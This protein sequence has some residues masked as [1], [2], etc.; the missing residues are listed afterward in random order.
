MVLNF[1]DI[2]A[3]A[4]R[5]EQHA[6]FVTF[7]CNTLGLFEGA[8]AS[9]EGPVTALIMERAQREQRVNPGL[10]D[11]LIGAFSGDTAKGMQTAHNRQHVKL[12]VRNT[13]VL[14]LEGQFRRAL[15]D[16]SERE[17]TV[18]RASCGHALA[19]RGNTDLREEML[20]FIFQLNAK[21]AWGGGRGQFVAS[22]QAARFASEAQTAAD[23]AREMMRRHINDDAASYEQ[24][25]GDMLSQF[26]QAAGHAEFHAR[27]PGSA[28]AV[29]GVIEPE[30]TLWA[31]PDHIEAGQTPFKR[32]QPG[33]DLLLG[34]LPLGAGWYPVGFAGHESLVTVAQPG[35]G[36]TQCHVLP[37]LLSYDGAM[38]VLDPKLELLELTAGHRQS[39]GKRILVLNLADDDQPSHKFNVL[40]FIDTRPEFLW[41]AV[42]E[43]AEFLIP[44]VPGDHSPIF[45]AKA[46]ELLATCLG[47]VVLAAQTAGETPTLTKA[48]AHIFSAPLSLQGFLLDTQDLAEELGCTPLAQSAAALAS[49][50]ANENTLEDFQRYQTNATSALMKYRGGLVDR[51][52]DGP[53]EWRPE[54]LR[55]P[56]TTLYIRIPYEEMSVYGG[57]VRLVLYT[58]I[59]RLRKTP[60]DQGGLPITFLLDEIAQLGNLDA[61]AN[62]I[63][64]GRGFGLRVWLILQDYDQARAASSKPNLI[65]KTPKVRLFM[66]PSLETAQ[67]MSAQLGSINEILTGKDKPIAQ[68]AELMGEAFNDEVV[69]LSSGCRPLCLK[70]Y[71]AYRE[72]GYT[73]MTSRPERFIR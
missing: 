8:E 24:E 51:V 14:L 1:D 36:K 70:K 66:N 68:P 26:V 57:F 23:M 44:E 42:I 3:L 34:C 5:A 67:E 11:Q 10:M 30:R 40:D 13:R 39:E 50:A 19:Q 63:E 15:A 27:Y 73:A 56:G 45:R 49:L 59:K 37:N 43:V 54:D 48:I 64:T 53:S 7:D 47:G 58:L 12:Y 41:G 61:I 6:G 65:L 38:V 71:F 72:E 17:L 4:Q 33:Q 25:I 31:K 18:L 46:A 21:L 62:V 32:F 29:A 22:A 16:L 52:A 28:Q 20:R 55:T 35:A 2:A 69:V 60:T 9:L